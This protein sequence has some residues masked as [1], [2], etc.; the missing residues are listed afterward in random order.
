VRSGGRYHG[1]CQ[2]AYLASN[3]SNSSTTIGFNM[4]PTD[5]LI[6]EE[7]VQTG[8]PSHDLPRHHRRA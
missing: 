1:L 2:G 7:I 4:L 3:F 6:D 5:I 8:V